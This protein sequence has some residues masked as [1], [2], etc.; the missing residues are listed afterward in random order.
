MTLVRQ[1]AVLSDTPGP[2]TY[3][4][5]PTLVPVSLHQD[6]R[7]N[8]GV[9]EGQSLPFAA[10]RLYFM[11]DMPKNTVRGEHAH[12]TLQQVMLCLSGSAEVMFW[13]GSREET[14]ELSSR[15]VG[16]YV[17]AGFWRRILIKEEGTVIAV[18]A[19]ELF[20]KGDY[21]YK[22]EDYLRYISGNSGR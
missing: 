5:W 21:I 19:S 3:G 11:F 4:R 9:V 1:P 8:L 12:K 16:I 20:D 17:P 18:L 14:F 13:D 2:G 6:E 22:K 15:D 10:K 7:G